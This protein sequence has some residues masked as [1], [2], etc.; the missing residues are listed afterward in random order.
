MSGGNGYIV[1][2]TDTVS[3]NASE[4]MSEV[5]GAL[6]IDEN[7]VEIET[8]G[9][10]WGASVIWSSVLAF[11]PVMPGHPRRHRHPLPRAAHGRRRAHLPVP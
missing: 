11:L 1:K 10:S 3:T 7:A 8:I 4:I 6:D 9:A 2:T 5:E